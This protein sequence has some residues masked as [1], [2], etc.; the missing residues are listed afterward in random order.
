M[1]SDTTQWCLT[2]LFLEVFVPRRQ[3]IAA[4]PLGERFRCQRGLVA[5]AA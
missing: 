3:Q 4:E 1:V 2:P 5:L